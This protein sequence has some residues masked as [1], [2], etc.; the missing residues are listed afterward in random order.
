MLIRWGGEEFL[1][2]L[3]NADGKAAVVAAERIRAALGAAE[4]AGPGGATL[5]I[6]VSIGVATPMTE[7]PP[8]LI[9]R[10]DR[11]LYAAK[12]RRPKPGGPGE[13]A[14]VSCLPRVEPDCLASGPLR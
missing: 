9:R 10:A 4:I 7:S 11:A 12:A 8:E 5:H 1:F 13:R 3:P 14:A 6:T 2:V